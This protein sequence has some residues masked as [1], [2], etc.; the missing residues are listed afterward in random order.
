M[1]RTDLIFVCNR[2]GNTQW[3]LWVIT[4][5]K[6]LP[7]SCYHLFSVVSKWEPQ[8]FENV[9]QDTSVTYLCEAGFFNILNQKD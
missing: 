7:L 3:Q 5:N 8:L 4:E 2:F 1:F 6:T 9:I